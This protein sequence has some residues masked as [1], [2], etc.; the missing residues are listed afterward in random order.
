MKDLIQQRI[1]TS[2]I[3]CDIQE[4]IPVTNLLNYM[5]LLCSYS[6]KTYKVLKLSFMEKVISRRVILKLV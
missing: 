4:I 2:L 5:L 6:I 1:F 3:C